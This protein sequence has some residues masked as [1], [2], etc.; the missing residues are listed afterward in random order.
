M[1]DKPCKRL[2]LSYVTRSLDLVPQSNSQVYFA[3]AKKGEAPL[4]GKTDT[5]PEGLSAV[6]AGGKWA[7]EVHWRLSSSD[8]IWVSGLTQIPQCPAEAVL[9]AGSS[10]TWN[11]S[12]PTGKRTCGL[13]PTWWLVP[14]I[15]AP[16]QKTKTEGAPE[17]RNHFLFQV[18]FF[19]S[20]ATYIL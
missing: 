2:N 12:K 4:D 6:N 7:R 9:P 20:S 8:L 14:Y 16:C 3:V 11:S 15:N 18:Y 1:L 13:L 17:V 10:A 5:D 19:L